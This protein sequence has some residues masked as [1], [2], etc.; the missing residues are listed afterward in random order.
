M[1]AQYNSQAIRR[2][3]ASMGMAD[4]PYKRSPGAEAGGGGGH[5][6]GGGER[7]SSKRAQGLVKKAL[8]KASC[9]AGRHDLEA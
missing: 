6:G 4:P 1:F 8:T 2:Q 3:R 7:H 5:G 9:V